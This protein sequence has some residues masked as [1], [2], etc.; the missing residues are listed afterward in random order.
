M[1]ST[2]M[3]SSFTSDAAA[4]CQFSDGTTPK[5]F[6][7][8]IG[9]FYQSVDVLLSAINTAIGGS[10]ITLSIVKSGADAGKVQAVASSGTVNIAWSS[11]GDGSKL[12]DFLG[13]SGDYSAE[14]SPVLFPLAHKGGFYPARAARKISRQAATVPRAF[15]SAISTHQY[16]QHNLSVN[17]GVT[18]E[19]GVEFQ[20]SCDDSDYSEVGLIDT[21]YDD[22]ASSGEI[23]KDFSL[24]HDSS[25]YDLGL[26]ESVNQMTFERRMQDIEKVFS[27]QQRYF[28]KAIVSD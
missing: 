9:S 20:I 25:R 3:Q 24:Y 22:L 16:T 28:V 7:L 15:G 13:A 18:Q 12:R 27:L 6:T 21:F 10:N 26:I 19:L 17:N 23:T 8:T 14:S 2:Y 4:I 11:A 5:N 1:I